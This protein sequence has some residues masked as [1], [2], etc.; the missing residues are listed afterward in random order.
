[1]EVK[2]NGRILRNE[3]LYDLYCPPNGI[4]VWKNRPMGRGGG[5]R[6]SERHVACTIVEEKLLQG[7]GAET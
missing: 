7:S 6:R 4:G 1:V 5:S 2:G 3:Q